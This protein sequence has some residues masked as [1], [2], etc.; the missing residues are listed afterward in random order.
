MTIHSSQLYQKAPIATVVSGL[1]DQ[2][3][4]DLPG[5]LAHAEQLLVGASDA[6]RDSLANLLHAGIALGL[7]SAF[8]SEAS[9]YAT[10][11][12]RHWPGSGYDRAA[13]DP[14]LIARF[15]RFVSAVEALRALVDEA[16]ALVERS[17]PDAARAAAVA[18]HHSISVG[19]QFI[20]STIE[21]LGASAV[22]V[23]L[24]YDGRWRAI[25]DHARKHPP[26]GQLQPA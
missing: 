23:K 11:K 2:A 19:S 24:G 17:S 25:L 5:A 10:T 4:S 13:D 15:G 8:L 16:A 18:R 21:L 1:A 26:R 12:T 14:H 3:G 6:D 7:L 22:S 9:T 20:S